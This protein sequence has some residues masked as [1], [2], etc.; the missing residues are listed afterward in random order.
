MLGGA[1]GGPDSDNILFMANAIELLSD[2]G[3]SSG[4]FNI[5]DFR[6]KQLDGINEESGDP[7]E[8]V[9]SRFGMVGVIG[10]PEE[11]WLLLLSHMTN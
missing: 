1:S 4:P 7:E 5:G 8:L 3:I 9:D 6:L 11:L 10:G 2:I